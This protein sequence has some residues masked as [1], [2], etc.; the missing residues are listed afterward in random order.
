VSLSDEQRERLDGLADFT[1]DTFLQQQYASMMRV[2]FVGEKRSG[3][4]I[5]ADDARQW[6]AEREW[7][8]LH[9]GMLA[10]IAFAVEHVLED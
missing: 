9:A 6:A 4:P 1:E 7:S 2:I 8:S 3:T 10:G 5:H